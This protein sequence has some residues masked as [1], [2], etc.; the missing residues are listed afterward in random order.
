MLKSCIFNLLKT[1]LMH[2]FHPHVSKA[3][4]DI[5]GTCF[6]KTLVWYR[7]YIAIS[8][9]WIR[10][11]IEHVHIMENMSAISLSYIFNNDIWDNWLA[12]FVTLTTNMDEIS[13]VVENWALVFVDP[14]KPFLWP[15][16]KFGVAF[17]TLFLPSLD[18][19]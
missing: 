10:V 17:D 14:E 4:I 16:K 3:C 7:T 9:D 19:F 5:I 6:I 15:W 12:I 11:E 8:Y 13:M 18:E 2:V 1:K